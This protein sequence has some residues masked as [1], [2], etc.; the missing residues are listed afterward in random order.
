GSTTLGHELGHFFGLPHTFQGWEN[1]NIPYDPELVTRGPGANCSFTGDYFC[2]TEADYL[3]IRW[4]C[5]YTGNKR[6][7]NGDDYQPDSSLYMS[8]ALA[9]C[10]SRFSSQQTGFMQYNLQNRTAFQDIVPGK[11]TGKYMLDSV[12]LILPFDTMHVNQKKIRWNK[13]SGAD[14]YQ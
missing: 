3:S 8:Y 1:G 4:A 12:N 7:P 9:P 2:D 14:Y 13:V 6:D 11:P 10:R 5:P